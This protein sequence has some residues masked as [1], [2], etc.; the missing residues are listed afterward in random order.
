MDP[1][2]LQSEEHNKM[3][4]FHGSSYATEQPVDFLFPKYENSE[5]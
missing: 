3:L 2:Q 1:A 4:Y 5:C